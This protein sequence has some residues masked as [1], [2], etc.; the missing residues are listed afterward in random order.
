M[1]RKLHKKTAFIIA[2][3]MLITLFPSTAL[4]GTLPQPT[5]LKLGIGKLGYTSYSSCATTLGIHF[6]DVSD[7][8]YN[9]HVVANGTYQ[10]HS[11]EDEGKGSIAFPFLPLF[12][13]MICDG[14]SMKE[15]HFDSV[16]IAFTDRDHESEGPSATLNTDI[17]VTQVESSEKYTAYYV[18]TKNPYPPD[19]PYYNPDDKDA[20]FKINGLPPEHSYD[21]VA[22]HTS[23]GSQ[24]SSNGTAVINDSYYNGRWDLG[25]GGM[26]VGANDAYYMDIFET[27]VT[28]D[29]TA[30]LT[31]TRHPVEIVFSGFNVT[32]EDTLMYTGAQLTPSISVTT[33]EDTPVTLT[34]NSD[35]TVSFEKNGA[36]ISA[37]EVKNAGDYTVVIKGKEG[38]AYEGKMATKT[39]TVAKATPI[40][41][42][43]PTGLTAVYG[44]TLADIALPS[45]FSW[46][47]SDTTPVGNVGTNTFQ[48]QYNLDAEN[49]HSVTGINL[50]IEVSK[51]DQRRPELTLSS[52]TGILGLTPPEFTLLADEGTGALHYVSSNPAVATVE[53]STGAITIITPGT[54]TFTVK[55]DG[56]SNYKD[57]DE[58]AGVT[59]IVNNKVELTARDTVATGPAL[60]AHLKNQGK[61]NVG[62]SIRTGLTNEFTVAVK[63][64]STL[65]TYASSDAAQGEAK[66]IG[67][68]IGNLK[69]NDG[70]EYPMTD[71]YYK[72]TESAIYL[73]LTDTDKSEALQVGGTDKE[74][75]LWMKSDVDTTKNIWLATSVDGANET[76]LTIHF[77][78]YSNSS[79][80]GGHGGSGGGGTPAIPQLKPDQTK[81]EG[82]TTKAT[83]EVKATVTGEK[84]NASI[85]EKVIADTLKAAEEAAK[86]A[87]TTPLVEIKVDAPKNMQKVSTTIPVSA[88][89]DLSKSKVDSLLINTPIGDLNLSEESMLSI[90]KQAG[91]GNITINAGKVDS[92]KELN[93]KQKQAIGDAPVYDFSI[94]SG[95]KAITKFDGPIT[96]SLPYE[97]K[98]GENPDGVTVWYVDSNGNIE[99]MKCVYDTKTKTVSFKTTHFSLYAIGYEKI[100]EN[101]FQDVK[102]NAWFF[103]S[104]QFVYEKGLFAGT[105]D[106]TFA[107]NETVS[108]AMLVTA[109]HRLAGKPQA[110]ANQFKDVTNGMWYVDAV[111]WASEKQIVNGYGDGVFG[112]NDNVT[113]EQ[114]AV[115]LYHYAKGKGYDISASGSLS[116]FTDSNQISSWAEEPMKWAI[117]KGLLSGKGANVLDPSSTATRAEVATILKL[118]IEVK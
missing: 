37:T 90:V 42:S 59:L 65:T 13:W 35:Y 105:S 110:G 51:A 88:L 103:K 106:T 79:S 92:S 27:S 100:W 76:K 49:Y 57:S 19:D 40:S 39:F 98:K 1:K 56:D 29:T 86:K 4:A 89:N 101:P 47:D 38:T 16:T 10:G 21:F 102:A 60:V 114:M 30:A 54:T 25:L 9:Y 96:I 97:L 18:G 11:W 46:Q 58:S 3:C 61:I 63:G 23:I 44:Q 91:D 115:I 5:G 41:P 94:M 85:S 22:G 2:L 71:L 80:G 107:P 67:L 75:V 68:L 112:P 99:P 83:T 118:F 81:T 43:A 31:I 78:P 50:S 82:T 28:N 72:T 45:G 74:L 116:T 52:S 32:V 73:R 6:D 108:R 109:L 26:E 33:I 104:V 66:W 69:V 14:Q 24:S 36:S 8:Y 34:E 20:T 117:G 62:E 7:E 113:R 84:A 77:T 93:E 111:N 95:T 64:K 70:T 15:R 55:K 53:E 48:A 12:D 17:T 87:G